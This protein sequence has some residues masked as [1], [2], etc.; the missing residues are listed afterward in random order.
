MFKQAHAAR[1]AL[2]V[3]ALA[4][5]GIYAASTALPLSFDD[6]W[7]VR[8]VRDFSPLD[9][10]FRTQNFG[11]YRPI[12]LAYYRL[13]AAAGAGGP[14]LLHALC[15]LTHAANTLLVA[16]LARRHAPTLGA[17][18]AVCAGAIFA[19]N[20][21]AAQA[22]ALPAGLN[23]LLALCFMLLALR[24]YAAA[25][26]S[27][28]WIWAALGFSLLGFLSNEVALSVAGFVLAMTLAQPAATGPAARRWLPLF[29]VAALA[30]AYAALY[31]LIPKG[32]A[33]PFF[34]TLP[35]MFERMAYAAQILA[36]PL[37][38]LLFHGTGLGSWA[39]AASAALA[40]IGFGLWQARRNPAWL[41]A[42][43]LFGAGAALPVLRLDSDYVRNAPRVF[44]AAGAGMALVWAL[45]IHQLA[46]RRAI[47][48]AVLTAA[49]VFTG[50][51][52]VISQIEHYAH[53]SEPAMVISA[54]ARQLDAS[55]RLLA[56]NVPEWVAVTANHFPLF[57]EGAIIMAPYVDGR[58]LAFANAGVDRDVD[59][60][61]FPVPDA[62]L[63][64]AY[65]AFGQTAPDGALAEHFAA[66]NRI[67]W[68]RYTSRTIHTDWIGGVIPA[69]TD[70]PIEAQF[71]GQLA[72][73]AHHIQLCNDR[74]ERGAIVALQWR[75]V[76]SGA[77]STTLSASAQLLD[78]QGARIAQADGAPLAGLLRFD[79]LPADRD[80]LERR[81]LLSDRPIAEGALL[82]SVYDYQTGARLRAQRPDGSGLQEDA[83]RLPLPVSPVSGVCA[84]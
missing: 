8:L 74:A 38:L 66:A 70:A 84:L 35:G 17:M 48:Q 21:F 31:P 36:W 78:P 65:R 20:P 28:R 25:Q 22:V 3:L 26:H 37:S 16:N 53:A 6:A 47:A 80:V 83:L 50:A 30:G 77:L 11:Y 1:L 44:Y 81:V 64:Y 4:S 14:L 62:G 32:A 51:W 75:R 82:I 56:L 69:Q 79:Q 58:D 5:A 73:V 49:L 59:L 43:L 42:L 27:P 60:I 41:F 46:G 52:H 9:L 40:V 76:G 61:Q 34:F 13:A 19:F 33:P 68:T 15:L 71:G 12:Y 57:S 45:L 39:S 10:L 67:T 18:G 29:A 23:H 24:C 72:L 2:V 7:S 54:Q 55:Q 63:P